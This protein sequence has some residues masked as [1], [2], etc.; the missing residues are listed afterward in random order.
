MASLAKLTSI[1]TQTLSLL[2][3]RQRLQTLSGP[4]T[5]SLHLP[6]IT[7]NLNQ[8]RLGIVELEEKGGNPEAVKLL[9]G[10]YERMRGML[11]PEAETAGIPSLKQTSSEEPSP[12]ASSSSLPR[13]SVSPHPPDLP[14][15]QVEGPFAPYTDDPEAAYPS[16]GELLQTQRQI[17]DDQ[18][19][20]LDNLSHSINR[21]RDL[22][23]QIN[24]ELEEHAGLLESLDEELDRTS[25]RLSGARRRLDKVAKGAKENGSTVM[26]G[27]LIFIPFSFSYILGSRLLR[28]NGQWSWQDSLFVDSTL[29]QNEIYTVSASWEIFKLPVPRHGHELRPVFGP[30][31][32]VT[33]MF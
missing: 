20:H 2:L 16:D 5:N 33:F 8:L 15:K 31:A 14:P 3:E 23:L 6:Q 1:S 29:A 30:L 9:K 19:L 12:A 24:G 32:L 11:G 7:R 28:P 27:V 26:I 25:G 21:Q 17:M 4:T 10:Q 18:D 22:S 13:S